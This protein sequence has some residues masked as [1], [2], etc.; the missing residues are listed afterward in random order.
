MSCPALALL[1]A[2][3]CQDPAPPV[4]GGPLPAGQPVAA[5]AKPGVLPADATREARA[6]FEELLL[7]VSG[8]P[9][10]RTPIRC[11][12]LEV[13]LVRREG[14]Q[15]NESGGRHAWLAPGFVRSSLGTVGKRE[16][17]RGPRGDFLIEHRDG[18]AT[19]Q[20]ALAGRE[21]ATDRKLLD[22]LSSLSRNF[23]LFS[24]PAQVVV[25]RLAL[26][27]GL[28]AEVS[29]RLPTGLRTELAQALRWLELDSPSFSLPAGEHAAATTVL[30]GLGSESRPR[31]AL[32]RTASAPESAPG[33]TSAAGATSAPGALG[34]AGSAA[35][36][37][38]LVLLDQD[39]ALQRDL[40]PNH[41]R[42]W[43]GLPE[44]GAWKFDPGPETE[45]WI[46]AANL[47]AALTPEHFV[48]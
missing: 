48:P 10:A 8:P 14:T 17:L 45:L 13:D 18:G 2:L 22:D 7:A 11:F 19:E 6:L 31:A 43:R 35:G 46:H 42:V 41:M 40:L 47:H 4:T 21:Y 24:D 3:V 36:E 33:A 34:A 38:L 12:E 30:L 1:C 9:E 28:P 27:P 37:V 25:T 5:A 39:L 29:A 32:I 15:R 16:Y 23:T 44:A 26:S 20:V